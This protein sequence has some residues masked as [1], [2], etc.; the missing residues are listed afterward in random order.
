MGLCHIH[1]LVGPHHRLACGGPGHPC[2]ADAHREGQPRKARH[3]RLGDLGLYAQQKLRKFVVRAVLGQ[4]E[5]LVAAEADELVAAAQLRLDNLGQLFQNA[6]SGA[7]TEV[8][9]AQLQVVQVE[10]GYEPLQGGAPDIFLVI[11]PVIYPRKGVNGVLPANFRY[12][13]LVAVDDGAD[14]QPGGGNALVGI[15]VVVM[16]DALIGEGAVSLPHGDEH[17]IV[18]LGLE[19]FHNGVQG[20][21]PDDLLLVLV[22]NMLAH[23]VGD[24][25]VVV[26]FLQPVRDGKGRVADKIAPGVHIR[27]EDGLKGVAQGPVH[28][29]LLHLRGLVV[30]G[31]DPAVLVQ[32][33]YAHIVPDQ[34]PVL[35]AEPE[36]KF[37]EPSIFLH[38]FRHAVGAEEGVGAADLKVVFLPDDP[39]QLCRV[40]PVIFQLDRQLVPVHIDFPDGLVILPYQVAPV[41]QGLNQLQLF[42]TPILPQIQ[43]PPGKFSIK[44]P[45]DR[46]KNAVK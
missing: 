4:K 15:V 32:L 33:F 36:V 40:V 43:Q 35:L 19:L 2:A 21:G 3:S 8:V 27:A 34:I 17:G 11:I 37:L 5:E 14:V 31:D 26:I 23:I 42:H 39:V 12:L 10:H 28:R 7:V 6:V 24:G 38:H 25:A 30:P 46:E 22:I 45:K 9:V 41:L 1:H 18:L 44:S 20:Q 13:R 29:A 16:Y